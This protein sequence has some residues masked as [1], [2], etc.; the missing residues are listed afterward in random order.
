MRKHPHSRGSFNTLPLAGQQERS[1]WP[2]PRVETSIRRGRRGPAGRRRCR[3][4]Q[5]NLL[6]PR[7]ASRSC[8]RSY[9]HPLSSTEQTVEIYRLRR[10][11]KDGWQFAMETR[12]GLGCSQ[13]TA[14][15]RDRPYLCGN[16]SLTLQIGAP[17][18]T[19][20]FVQMSAMWA[21]RNA[22]RNAFPQFA[23]MHAGDNDTHR[24]NTPAS[25]SRR[26]HTWVVGSQSPQSCGHYIEVSNALR[27]IGLV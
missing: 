15:G 9:H 26:V 19:G 16:A 1:A 7:R 5:E 12:P 18:R 11:L 6:R 3:G 14:V 25:T 4:P 27:Q 20:D 10:R 21:K 13:S 8:G 24:P 2:G 23:C 17:S 22:S